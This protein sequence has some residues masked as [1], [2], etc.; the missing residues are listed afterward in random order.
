MAFQLLHDVARGK[1]ADAERLIA[2]GG[3][4][5]AIIGRE[6]DAV[7]CSSGTSRVQTGCDRVTSQSRSV[8]SLPVEIRWR[9]SWE[10]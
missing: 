5:P 9:P 7:S 4:N 10:T 3:E 1:V 8:P 6:G 2:A